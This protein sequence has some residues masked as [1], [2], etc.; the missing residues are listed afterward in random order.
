M[1]SQEPRL[2]APYPRGA[3]EAVEEKAWNAT[4]HAFVNNLVIHK[5]SQDTTAAQLFVL[6][7]APENDCLL[8]Y[9]ACTHLLRATRQFR[10]AAEHIALIATLLGLLKDEGI[11]RDSPDGEDAFE[12]SFAGDILR[13]LGGETPPVPPGYTYNEI[14]FRLDADPG[15][16]KDDSFLTE[17]ARYGREQEGMVR[18]WSLAGRLEADRILG[19]PGGM[20]LLLNGGFQDAFEDPRQ[21]RVWETL[22]AAL[23]RCGEDKTFGD[24]DPETTRCYMEIARK[25]A[26]DKRASWEWRGRFAVRAV[27]S[28][29]MTFLSTRAAS[30]GGPREGNLTLIRTGFGSQ[31]F[32]DVQRL[33]R[34]HCP[35]CG[36]LVPRF[37]RIYGQNVVPPH[38]APKW[39]SQHAKLTRGDE[40]SGSGTRLI[41]G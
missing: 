3:N 11:R 12:F 1:A 33:S 5:L 10:E 6:F 34:I 40:I 25:I 30:G 28:I 35:E 24:W 16:I 26:R 18:L 41:L 14:T 38:I 31:V 29:P 2:C 37:G 32:V 20:S 8:F 15:Y 17:L 7:D 23:L 39:K 13:E 9:V 27:F 21:C 36:A 19:S 22:W 4:I